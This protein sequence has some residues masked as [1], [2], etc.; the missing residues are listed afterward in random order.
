[1]GEKEEWDWKRKRETEGKELSLRARVC[2]CLHVYA[3]LGVGRQDSGLLGSLLP[4][5]LLS[6]SHLLWAPTR[7]DTGQVDSMLSFLVYLNHPELAVNSTT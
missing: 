6:L 3:G 1:M 4:G 7:G 5:P 2:V